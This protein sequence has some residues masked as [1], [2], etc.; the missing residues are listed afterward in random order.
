MSEH[1]SSDPFRVEDVDFNAFYE[2]TPPLTG[3]DIAFG[4][5]PWDIGEPQPALVALERRGRLRSPL[6]DAG[7]GLGENAMFLAERGYQVTAFDG[8][9]TAL[10][11][12]RERARS[13]RIHIEF[14]QADATHLDRLGQRFRTVIDSALYHCLGAAEQTAYAEALHRVTLPEAD[15][16][17]FCISDASKGFRMPCME[18]SGGDLRTHLAGR[19]DIRSIEAA[20]YTTALTLETL[21]R[22]RG[23]LQAI[24][25]EVDGDSLDIDDRGRVLV[26]V[27]RVHAVRV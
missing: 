23:A 15:L 20:R 22:H 6:L 18:V 19:W 4:V 11:R 2:G 7:C 5:I 12:A 24:G 27:W 21:E 10:A 13:R 14:A 26:P 8:S 25:G 17:I 3:V 9:E 16:H 1:V